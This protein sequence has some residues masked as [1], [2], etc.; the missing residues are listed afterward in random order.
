LG[1]TSLIEIG[2]VQFI[3]HHELNYDRP[4]ET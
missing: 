1:Q 2:V 3:F 4:Y